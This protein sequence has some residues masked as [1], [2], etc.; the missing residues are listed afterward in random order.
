MG[1]ESPVRGAVHTSGCKGTFYAQ[2]IFLCLDVIGN[3]FQSFEVVD[4]IDRRNHSA[5][6]FNV[7]VQ[8]CL[9]VDQAVSLDHVCD[10]VNFAVVSG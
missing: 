5:F 6:G 8:Q 2:F 3:C 10:T 9:V 7:F 1:L 4:L